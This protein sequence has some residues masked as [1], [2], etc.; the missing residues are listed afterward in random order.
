[1]PP[2]WPPCGATKT[3]HGPRAVGFFSLGVRVQMSAQA[4]PHWPKSV[5]VLRACAA[6]AN[7]EAL[8]VGYFLSNL[9]SWIHLAH[10][11]I[12][13]FRGEDL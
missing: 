11:A 8:G 12:L 6:S 2:S 10:P 5:G 13:H 4:P 9:L 3:S 7:L 1:M